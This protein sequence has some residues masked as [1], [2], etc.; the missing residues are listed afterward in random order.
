MIANPACSAPSRTREHRLRCSAGLCREDG[1]KQ[2]QKCHQ[3]FLGL[4]RASFLIY[5]SLGCC[6]ALPNSRV[7]TNW[8]W[9]FPLAS[10]CFWGGRGVWKLPTPVFRKL[11]RED[12]FIRLHWSSVC[13]VG[14]RAHPS[15]FFLKG[16]YSPSS[17]NFNLY[18]HQRVGKYD[19]LSLQKEPRLHIW[20]R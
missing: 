1:G 16:I 17:K 5:C 8:F 10:Q 6:K 13:N 19:I 18:W 14:L 11:F 3:A 20:G 15:T 7:L 4:F 12:I 9:E 2:E